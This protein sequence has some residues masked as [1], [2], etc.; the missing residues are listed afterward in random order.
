MSPL[1]SC[2]RLSPVFIGRIDPYAGIEDS[3][4]VSPI[5]A[6]GSLK[7]CR[8]SE[9]VP[10]LLKCAG[11]IYGLYFDNKIYAQAIETHIS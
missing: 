2:D 8:F 3:L 5:H 11:A 7:V 1:S 10:A 4:S 6:H 9:K